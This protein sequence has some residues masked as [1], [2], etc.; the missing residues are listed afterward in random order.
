MM[1]IKEHQ[2]V[3][4][5]SFLIKKTGS[6][7]SV[8]EKLAERSYKPV[9]KKFKRGK[10]IKIIFGLQIQLKWDFFL[11]RIQMLDIYFV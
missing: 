8:N 4:S 7:V 3:C 1:D 9:I 6:G 11:L 5:L 2:K 10:D